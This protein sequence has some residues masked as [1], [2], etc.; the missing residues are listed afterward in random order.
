MR[1]WRSLFA[2][3]HKIKEIHKE[4]SYETKEAE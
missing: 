2:T 3:R 4:L 1:E